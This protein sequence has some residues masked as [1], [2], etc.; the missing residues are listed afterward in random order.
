MR[1][2]KSRRAPYGAVWLVVWVCSLFACGRPSWTNVERAVLTKRIDALEDLLRQSEQEGTS[3]FPSDQIIVGIDESLVQE[4]LRL[5]LPREEV[6]QARYRVRLE[7]A[8]VSFEHNF[9]LVR[10][11][12]RVTYIG[13]L[14]ASVFAEVS[15]YGTVDVVELDRR[16][17]LLHGNLSLVALEVHRTEVFVRSRTARDLADGLA[18][19]GLEALSGLAA[20]VEIPVQLEEKIRMTGI[21]PEGPVTIQPAVVPLRLNVTRVLALG[22]KLWVF[23]DVRAGED[24]SAE[25]KGAEGNGQD[26][27]QDKP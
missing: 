20:P 17:G 21:G 7:D 11:D 1:P 25:G 4:C 2:R 16:S 23:I 8:Q 13:S 19:L 3:L 5:G 12:G 9:G 18:D 14:E 10:L 27:G 6:V 22:G 24:K 15:L 26:A